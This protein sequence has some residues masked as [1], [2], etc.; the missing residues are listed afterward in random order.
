MP[1]ATRVSGARRCNLV[2]RITRARRE[3]YARLAPGPCVTIQLRTKRDVAES[4][5]SSVA[6][7]RA[8]C[9]RG[10]D[11]RDSYAHLLT[12]V[13]VCWRRLDGRSATVSAKLVRSARVRHIS[14]RV[15][16][17]HLC[18]VKRMIQKVAP[19][20]ELPVRIKRR[21]S[22]A[23]PPARERVRALLQ[24]C[25]RAPLQTTPAVNL[26]SDPQPGDPPHHPSM[27]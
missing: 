21:G 4:S 14:C 2:L 23:A 6:A 8:A 26:S 18:I 10:A 27:I 15:A 3:H 22:H 16:Q 12:L 19:R 7:T 25:R 13:L 5:V 9:D 24:R 17:K 20:Q 1:C 11:T